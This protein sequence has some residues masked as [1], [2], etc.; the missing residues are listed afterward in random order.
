MVERLVRVGYFYSGE[1]CTVCHKP[2]PSD[3][4]SCLNCGAI[5]C[6]KCDKHT[7]ADH[8]FCMSC[9][10]PTGCQNCGRELPAEAQFC[11]VCGTSRQAIK[12]R[13]VGKVDPFVAGS[14]AHTVSREDAARASMPATPKERQELEIHAR[15]IG[16]AT[17]RSI[18]ANLLGEPALLKCQFVAV[19]IINGRPRELYDVEFVRYA[20]RADSIENLG[21]MDRENAQEALA[22]IHELAVR[23]GWKPIT[24]GAHWYSYRYEKWAG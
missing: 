19:G 24:K 4:K 1:V 7:P 11:P 10:Y 5:K 8:N 21:A 2:S 23:N 6:R 9:G 14:T 20:G 17:G 16:M 15:E 3:S 18:L 13:S 22:S 12:T